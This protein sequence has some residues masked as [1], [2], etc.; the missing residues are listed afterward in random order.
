MAKLLKNL[1]DENYIKVLT[2][3]ISLNYPNFNTHNFINKVFDSFWHNKELKQ[4]MRHISTTLYDFLEHDYDKAIDIL[5]LT[6][7]KMNHKYMLENM[8]FQDFVEVYGLNHF[9]KSME[10]LECFTI[11]SSSEFAIRV[12]I[13][14]YPDET[15]KQMELWAKSENEHIRRLSCEGCRPRLPWAIALREFK[16][17]PQKILNILDIL[18]NDKS[19]YVRKSVANNINDISKDNPKIVKE[20]VKKWIGVSKDLDS[21]LKHGCRTLLKQGDRDIL[22]IFGFEEDKNRYIDNFTLNNKIK[23][24]DKLEFSFFLNSTQNLGKIRVEY[25]IRFLRQNNKLN[26]KVFKIT[27]KTFNQ[28]SC[29]ISKHYSFKPI[30]TRKYYKGKHRLAIIINGAI[31]DEKEFVLI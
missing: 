12:F 11:N 14:K 5:K 8:I 9:K 10:A 13:L 22:E 19:K 4:R 27:E 15:M 29:E 2:E 25:A 31:L 3:Y 16:K 30:S 24:G 20:I 23:M 7:N 21:I 28:K 26:T 1:Y 18:K 6:F 17:N